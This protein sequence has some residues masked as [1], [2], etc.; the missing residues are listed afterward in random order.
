MRKPAGEPSDVAG[1]AHQDFRFVPDTPGVFHAG[2]F[3]AGRGDLMDE[4]PP[5]LMLNRIRF[6][7]QAPVPPAGER[8]VRSFAWVRRVHTLG[9]QGTNCQRAAQSWIAGRCDRAEI[10]LHRSMEQAAGEAAGRE[11]EVMLGVVAYPELHSIIYRHLQVMRL[12]DMFIMDTDEMVLAVRPDQQAE[13][14]L[15]ATHPAPQSLLPPRI[16]RRFVSSTAIA[17]EQCAQGEAEGCITTLA[18]AGLN[19]L[20][21]LRRYGPVPMGFTIHGP[22]SPV[23]RCCRAHV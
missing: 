13:P 5:A 11:R 14:R 20:H 17:A 12:I 8:L 16:E 7:T 23:A 2:M 3:R 21:I 6:S 1:V 15:C 22:S 9:P 19:G 4:R 10:V 18:A